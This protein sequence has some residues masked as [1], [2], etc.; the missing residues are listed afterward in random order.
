MTR[1]NSHSLQLNDQEEADF[2]EV[3]KRTGYGIKKIFMAMVNALKSS[4]DVKIEEE[5]V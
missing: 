1:Y 5:S 3:K 4:T 2:N